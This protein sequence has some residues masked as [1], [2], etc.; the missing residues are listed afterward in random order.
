MILL[1]L[2]DF[3][4]ILFSLNKG[5][6]LKHSRVFIFDKSNIYEVKEQVK[7][8]SCLKISRNDRVAV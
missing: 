2:H 8:C 3:F 7:F 5:W 6:N 1:W 4:I